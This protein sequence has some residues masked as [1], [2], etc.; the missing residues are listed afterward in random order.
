MTIDYA[1]VYLESVVSHIY[2]N[3]LKMLSPNHELCVQGKM[4]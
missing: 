2:L 1:Q 3:T 4:E